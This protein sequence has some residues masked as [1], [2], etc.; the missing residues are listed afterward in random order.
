MS[1]R[2][3]WGHSIR[4]RITAIATVLV[5]VVLAGTVLSLA[6]LQ[7]RSLEDN[8][9]DAIEQRA[10][11]LTD[12]LAA[13]ATDVLV[14]SG[15]EDTVAQV[16]QDGRVIVAAP[17]ILGAPPMAPPPADAGDTWRTVD[18]VQQGG[19][20]HMVLSRL[21]ETPQ[22]TVTLHV[23]GS[24]GDIEEAQRALFRALLLL[25]PLAA[26][27]LAAATWW[28]TGRTL[29]PVEEIRAEVDEI[30]GR[31]LHRRVPQPRGNDE[32]ARLAATMNRM[33]DRVQ[34]AHA[35]QERFVGDASHEL[36]TPLTRMRAELDV[37][38]ADPDQAAAAAT[39]RSLLDETVHM[40]HL[41]DDLLLLA[42]SDQGAVGELSPV[43][44]DDIVF[45]EA[46]RLRALGRR[47]VDVSGVGAAQVLGD[48]HRL[49]RVV[50]NLA[51]NAERHAASIVSFSLTERDGCAV[52]AVVDDGPG[53]PAGMD[54][55]IF[56][57]FGRADQAR[58][59]HD[60]GAGLGLSIAREIVTRA[61][62]TLE[63]DR[64]HQPGA[65]FVVSL[66]LPGS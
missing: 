13:G 5:A 24:L 21:V 53:V 40:Q 48:P 55:V 16:V 19:E 17:S 41:V 23:A 47:A 7:R 1:E 30:G 31:E 15:G 56:E 50:A 51:D 12:L 18:R 26:L 38:L 43:D 58:S 57:R 45:A 37:S 54:A 36:R 22:G 25:V 63:L 9:H 52:L 49:R 14:T 46:D 6:A 11:D 66:P 62:G 2:G 64:A 20:A 44:L 65:R 33:L 42:R 8:L 29:S 39:Y 27:L 10:D 28:L 4:F 34:R 35:A 60:G 32:I 61:G 59:A 3:R